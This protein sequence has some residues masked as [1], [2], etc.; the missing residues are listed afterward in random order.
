MDIEVKDLR[1][2]IQEAREAAFEAT[3]DYLNKHGDGY[4]CGSAW[5]HLH[6]FDGKRLKGNT[7]IGK[8]LKAAGVEQN[9]SRVFEIWNP[10]GHFTQNVVAKEE[11]ARAA[12]NVFRRYGFE[13]YPGSRLD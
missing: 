8:A 13:A 5:V 1:E 7:K 3:Q 10:S 4:P 9:Y 12:A 6:K 11:G 2:I